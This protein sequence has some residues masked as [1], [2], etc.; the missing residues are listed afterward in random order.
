MIL[1]DYSSDEESELRAEFDGWLLKAG[2]ETEA[3]THSQATAKI[4]ISPYISPVH[5]GINLLGMPDTSIVG[6]LQ[7]IASTRY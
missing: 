2:T 3:M 5:V 7:P 4:I 6:Q 1:T